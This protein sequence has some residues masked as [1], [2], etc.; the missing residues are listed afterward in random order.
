MSL[1]LKKRKK[2]RKGNLSQTKKTPAEAVYGKKHCLQAE[3]IPTSITF[4][5]V[6]PLGFRAPKLIPS[7]PL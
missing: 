6:R 4:L 5:I 1:L 2:N 7:P 3:N